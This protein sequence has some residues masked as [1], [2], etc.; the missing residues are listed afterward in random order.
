MNLKGLL[1]GLLKQEN[2]YIPE[3]I[4]AHDQSLFKNKSMDYD[5]Y[6]VDFFKKQI[7]ST[8][9]PGSVDYG[10]GPMSSVDI[11]AEI[12]G[13]SNYS[14]GYSGTNIDNYGE[15]NYIDQGDEL[16]FY[17]KINP[18]TGLME[19]YT[20]GADW[21]DRGIYP[22]G[23]VSNEQI[24]YMQNNLNQ[25]YDNLSQSMDK[26]TSLQ[27]YENILNPEGQVLVGA[28]SIIPGE[29]YNR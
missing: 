8:S 13:D 26:D 6:N 19:W 22:E 16:G 1:G 10:K 7:H 4:S 27:Q 28:P 9:L 12:G 17:Q 3:D 25:R 23:F 20:H 11:E 5:D 15:F 24:Q 21:G 18:D 2:Q 14:Q 29:W